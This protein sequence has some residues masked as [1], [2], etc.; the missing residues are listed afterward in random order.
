MGVPSTSRPCRARL[1]GVSAV[2]A[3]PRLARN[4]AAVALISIAAAAI[5]APPASAKASIGYADP[6]HYIASW[7]QRAKGCGGFLSPQFTNWL[8]YAHATVGAH[9][10]VRVSQPSLCSQA[11]Q[12]GKKLLLSAPAS[13]GATISKVEMQRYA[14]LFGQQGRTDDLLTPTDGGPPG[15]RCYA[16]PSEWG[17]SAWGF[18]ESEGGSGRPESGAFGSASGAA[19]GAGFCVAGAHAGAQGRW[20]GGSFFSWAPNPTDCVTDYELRRP[21][22]IGLEPDPDNYYVSYDEAQIW[23]SYENFPCLG[24][25]IVGQTTAA[26]TNARR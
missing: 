1:G 13:D 6:A 18:A 7:Q 8:T 9:W 20:D 12:L 24:S 16:L 17:E 5:S 11:K 4:G 25:G 15:W 26:Q 3:W 14:L 21:P 23:G 2:E 22:E 19:A 10:L